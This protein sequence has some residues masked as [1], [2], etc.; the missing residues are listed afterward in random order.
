MISVLMN[1]TAFVQSVYP[2]SAHKHE[3]V[4][5]TLINCIVNDGLVH[6]MP[7]VHL[8]LLEFVNVVHPWLIHSLLDDAPY[9]IVDWSN[10]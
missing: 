4:H 10:K 7:N 2:L 8:M 1:V 5:A 3:N 9:L 6:A